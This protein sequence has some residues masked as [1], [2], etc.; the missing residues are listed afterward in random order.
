MV[1][2]GEIMKIFTLAMIAH[3]AK[4]EDLLLLIESHPDII[5][6]LNLIATGEIAAFIREKTK[7]PVEPVME[8]SLGGDIQI[9]A[10]AAQG[11]IDAVIFLRDA[12][13]PPENRLDVSPLLRVCDIHDVPLATNL[14]T[15][16]AVLHLM[17]DYPEALAGHHLAAGL[18]E[19]KAAVHEP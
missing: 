1:I 11:E 7:L 10:M 14:S 16:E 4:K 2:K 15:A 17:S 8:S 9:G 6:K 13:V 18:I 3:E 12:A 5:C 19:K